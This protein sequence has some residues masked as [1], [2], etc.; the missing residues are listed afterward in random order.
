VFVLS[1]CANLQGFLDLVHE[2]YVRP[3][4]VT[5]AMDIFK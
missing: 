5:V 2:V 4:E 1:I 3:I